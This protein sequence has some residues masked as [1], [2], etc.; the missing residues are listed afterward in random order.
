MTARSGKQE[1]RQTSGERRPA[2]TRAVQ[3]AQQARQAERAARYEQIMVFQK[4]GMKQAEIALQLGVTQRTIQRWIATGT[5]P[6]SGPRRQRPR[7]IDPYKTY[8]L[9]RWH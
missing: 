6:Y 8:L 7:L 5:I 1:T 9:K 4:E 3:H 2:R